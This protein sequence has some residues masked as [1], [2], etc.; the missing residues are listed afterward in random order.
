MHRAR[1]QQKHNGGQQP[2]KSWRLAETTRCACCLSVSLYRCLSL[3]VSISVSVC[4]YLYLFFSLCLS[5]DKTSLCFD[6]TS[7]HPQHNSL[8]GSLAIIPCLVASLLP[9]LLVFPRLL[10]FPSLLLFPRLLHLPRLLLSP[11]LVAFLR[12]LPSYLP[13][14]I[15]PGACLCP[16]CLSLAGA[17]LCPACI[18]L[19]LPGT[20]RGV[21]QRRAKGSV[22]V[23][24]AVDLVD[25]IGQR[26]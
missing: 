7:T 23:S 26:Q 15:I 18:S 19:Q 1:R 24:E 17:C 4:F 20:C 11:R 2:G 25:W 22:L 21:G 5:S 6:A 13:L 14:S 10:L 3:C 16:A 9:R 8:T 12:L